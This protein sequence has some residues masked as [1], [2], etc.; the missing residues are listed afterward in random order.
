[1]GQIIYEAR[2]NQGGYV[3]LLAHEKQATTRLRLHATFYVFI[4]QSR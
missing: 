4:E 3:T 1:M 2:V